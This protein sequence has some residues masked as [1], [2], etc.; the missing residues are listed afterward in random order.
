MAA[1]EQRLRR[2]QS[3]AFDR[4]HQR[5]DARRDPAVEI[6]HAEAWRDHF[7]LDSLRDG[8]GD[9]AF[10]AVAD[11][12]PQPAVSFRH[13]EDHAV[14]DSRAAYLPGVGDADRILLD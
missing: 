9:R 8:V 4:L 1:L 10:E 7:A 12:D 6:A 13:Q 2:G 11:F 3:L 14:V 5:I